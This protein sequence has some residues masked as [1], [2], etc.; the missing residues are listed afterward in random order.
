M[1]QEVNEETFVDFASYFEIASR[2]KKY[3]SVSFDQK[4]DWL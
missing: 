4:N 3:L 1:L 2:Y